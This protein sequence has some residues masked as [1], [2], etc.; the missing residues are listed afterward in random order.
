MTSVALTAHYYNSASGAQTW[1]FTCHISTSTS[2][3]VICFKQ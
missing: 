1:S 3:G 2:G